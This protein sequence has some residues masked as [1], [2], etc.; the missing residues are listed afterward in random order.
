MCDTTVSGFKCDQQI[1]S[2]LALV[3]SFCQWI[4]MLCNH[5]V[6]PSGVKKTRH[7]TGGD[8]LAWDEP[9]LACR[10][11]I[12]VLHQCEKGEKGEA[13]HREY[14]R[15]RV[16]RRG[17][18]TRSWRPL[19]PLVRERGDS[20]KTFSPLYRQIC[21]EQTA[22]TAAATTAKSAPKHIPTLDYLWGR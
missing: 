20:V 15:W 9:I 21:S 4:C 13:I 8:P 22:R 2:L 5:L 7:K 14:S 6:W 17:W 19:S 18:K 3:N 11:E 12:G 1:Q 10:L 16:S